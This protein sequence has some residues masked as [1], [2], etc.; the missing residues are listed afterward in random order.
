MRGAGPDSFIGSHDCPH[1]LHSSGKFLFTELDHSSIPPTP[2]CTPSEPKQDSDGGKASPV[3]RVL[4]Q[5]I[6]SWGL[7]L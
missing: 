1:L 7:S 4:R 3:Q 6:P 2:A 5:G